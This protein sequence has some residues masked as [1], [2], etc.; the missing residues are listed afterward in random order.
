MAVERN[1]LD[2][3]R[4]RCDRL[5]CLRLFVPRSPLNDARETRARAELY[6]WSCARANSAV[7][8]PWSGAE[9]GG[10]DFCPHHVGERLVAGG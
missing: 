7:G 10:L 4:V 9:P 3:V 2:R 5:D 6:G 8:S 1:A